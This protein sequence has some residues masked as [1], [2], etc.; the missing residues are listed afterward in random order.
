MIYNAVDWSQLETTMTRDEFRAS[1]GVPQDAIAARHHRAADRAEGAPRAVRCDGAASAAVGSCTWSWSGDGELRESLQQR[2]ATLGLQQRV[3]FLGARRDL[4]NILDA[5]DL[6]TMPSL[7]EGLPLSLVLA[8]GAGLP[9][10]A[11][12]V[13]GIPEVVQHDVSGLLVDRRA[14]VTSSAHALARLVDD[15]SLR[16]SLGERARAF[17]TPR[18]GVDGYVDV[19]H[20]SLRSAAGREGLP[21]AR[22]GV[23]LGILYHMPFWQTADGALWEAEGS[24]ARYVDS[25]APYFDQV[26]LSVPVFDTPPASGSRVR[27]ANVVLAPLPYFPGPAAVLSEAAV[28]ADAA[29]RLGGAV[30]RDSSA[31]AEPGR[32]LRVSHRARRCASRCSCWWSAT[33]RRCCRTSA[34]AASR[35]R[36]SAPTWRSRSGRFAT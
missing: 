15:A 22:D 31:R 8:M 14:T 26:I 13:A 4:G 9:V 3:H 10:V 32:D 18:F 29:A 5:V 11:T 6:F 28:D 21:Q 12:R 19:D 35:R 30:R 33:T 27:A 34:I 36:C 20:R 24:F 1:I 25:L 23:T 17:V 7:W 16:A 2:V